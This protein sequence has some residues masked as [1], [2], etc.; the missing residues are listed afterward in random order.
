ML[1]ENLLLPLGPI[2][3]KKSKHEVK[4]KQTEPPSEAILLI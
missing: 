3:Y 2:R 1:T 4:K